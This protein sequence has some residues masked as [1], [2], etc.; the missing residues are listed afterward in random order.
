M[1]H[2][3]CFEQLAC[4]VTRSLSIQRNLLAVIQ[5]FLIIFHKTCGFIIIVTVFFPQKRLPFISRIKHYLT[6]GDKNIQ[7]MKSWILF[8]MC[9]VHKVHSNRD[10]DPFTLSKILWRYI[11][12]SRSQPNQ[13]IANI[14]KQ[15]IDLGKA[16]PCVCCKLLRFRV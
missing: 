9:I 10:L 16:L 11:I 2:R 5:L 8:K 6:R 13:C 14:Y 4:V 1:L 12:I 3:C 15:L 7:P